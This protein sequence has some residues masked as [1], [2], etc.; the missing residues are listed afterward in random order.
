MATQITLASNAIVTLGDVKQYLRKSDADTG[1]DDFLT[2][3]INIVSDAIEDFIHG[4]VKMQAFS[5]IYDGNGKQKLVVRHRPI[6]AIGTL[7]PT[8]GAKVAPALT[9]IQYRNLPTDSWVDLCTRLG[10]IFVKS[11]EPWYIELYDMMFPYGSQNIKIEQLAGYETIPGRYKKVV[12]EAVAEM[13]SESP[14][15]LGRLGQSSVSTSGTGVGGTTS[16]KELSDRHQ[17]IL[18]GDV[19]WMSL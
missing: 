17:K 18:A 4:P 1:D 2:D 16:Y 7:D 13:L 9:N 10:Y 12:Y 14:R 19:W 15:G 6:I 8:S 11:S 5:D 3:A